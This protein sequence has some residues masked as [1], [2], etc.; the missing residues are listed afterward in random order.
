MINIIRIIDSL[1]CSGVFT[2]DCSD[3]EIP[4]ACNDGNW[5]LIGDVASD[6]VQEFRDEVN[7]L[8]GDECDKWYDGESA[9]FGWKGKPDILWFH[10][11]VGN[12]L[13]MEVSGTYDIGKERVITPIRLDD[14]AAAWHS[15]AEDFL[16]DELKRLYE[17]DS[18]IISIPYLEKDPEDASKYIFTGYLGEKAPL[19][20]SG[21][22]DADSYTVDE[23]LSEPDGSRHVFAYEHID[24]IADL[25]R[26]MLP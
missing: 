10:G 3:R 12:F 26:E 20:F 7:C 19:Q 8:P 5:S 17:S 24:E 2:P 25:I 16:S 4:F 13:K 18:D 15:K 9:D 1:N 14:R 21:T 11:Y 23:N 22:F 6:I